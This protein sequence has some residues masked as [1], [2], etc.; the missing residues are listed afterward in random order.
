MIELINGRKKIVALYWNNSR[1][2]T[3]AQYIVLNLFASFIVIMVNLRQ[4]N[5][6]ANGVIVAANAI[7]AS[8]K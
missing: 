3:H 2:Y 4:S 7:N 1:H 8:Q 6:I 5:W